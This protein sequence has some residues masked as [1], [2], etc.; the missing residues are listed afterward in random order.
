MKLNMSRLLAAAFML[1]SVV[2]LTLSNTSPVNAVGDSC[3]TC[4]SQCNAEAQGY[5]ERCMA[6]GGEFW[7]CQADAM[8]Y[9]NNCKRVFCQYTGLCPY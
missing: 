8:G 9:N 7:S 3:K 5:Y 2:A 4:E 1:L 6:G